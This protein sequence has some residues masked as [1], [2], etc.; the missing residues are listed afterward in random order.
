VKRYLFEITTKRSRD[1]D[2]GFVDAKN[3]DAARARLTETFGNYEEVIL[4]ESEPD[5][6]EWANGPIHFL[7]ADG[8]HFE[9]FERSGEAYELRH[10]GADYGTYESLYSAIW[11]ADRIDIEIGERI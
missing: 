10:E 2:A 3:E 8:P 7:A 4:D 1:T 11:H 9:I 5:R 6:P